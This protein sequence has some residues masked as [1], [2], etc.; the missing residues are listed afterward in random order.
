MS[1]LH[2][3]GWKSW[4]TRVVAVVSVLGGSLTASTVSVANKQALLLPLLH[5]PGA[6]SVVQLP[7]LVVLA[8]VLVKH[9]CYWTQCTAMCLVCAVELLALPTHPLRVRCASQTSPHSM[10]CERNLSWPRLPWGPTML[11]LQ[12]CELH[13]AFTKQ[14]PL[15]RYAGRQQADKQHG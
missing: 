7:L 5:A 3:L 6:L 10:T 1:G 8:C 2:V 13:S 11:Q 4:K 12:V 9:G 14:L 15:Q